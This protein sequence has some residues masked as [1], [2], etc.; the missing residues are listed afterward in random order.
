MV[1]IWGGNKIRV[2]YNHSQVKSVDDNGVVN[3][4]NKTNMERR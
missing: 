1:I 4:A 2:G 3:D